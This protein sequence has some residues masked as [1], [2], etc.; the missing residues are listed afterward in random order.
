MRRNYFSSAFGGLGGGGQRAEGHDC[1]WLL[2]TC[3]PGR[4]VMKGDLTHL[5]GGCGVDR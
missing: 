5:I 3:H 2:Q 1:D 4:L